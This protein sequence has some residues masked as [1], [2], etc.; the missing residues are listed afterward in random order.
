MVAKIT[1]GLAKVS[2]WYDNITNCLNFSVCAYLPR[3]FLTYLG[4]WNNFWKSK[5]TAVNVKIQN[6]SQTVTFWMKL[7]FILP[8]LVNIQKLHVCLK[9]QRIQLYLNFNIANLY[10]KCQNGILHDKYFT[11]VVTMEILLFSFHTFH[12]PLLS[13]FYIWLSLSIA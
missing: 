10:Q 8:M 3:Y 5:K 11:K 4:F 1:H 2:L 6:C 7:S 12:H 9:A 13:L